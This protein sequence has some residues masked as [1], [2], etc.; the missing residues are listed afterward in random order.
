MTD[1]MLPQRRR[2]ADGGGGDLQLLVRKVPRDLHRW[3]GAKCRAGRTQ[4]E[5]LLELL[6]QAMGRELGGAL[7][8]AVPNQSP[9]PT[10]S[11]L[12]LRGDPQTA[13]LRSRR[14]RVRLAAT[15]RLTPT[16]PNWW[17]RGRVCRRPSAGGSPRRPARPGLAASTGSGARSHPHRARTAST[18]SCIT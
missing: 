2:A 18:S 17:R 6:H 13:A 16:S 12:A 1:I 3:L 8:D 9:C 4:N 10:P 11:G 14:G 15:P 7:F 5:V